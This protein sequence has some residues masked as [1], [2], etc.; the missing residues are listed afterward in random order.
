M[1]YLSDFTNIH[2][3]IDYIWLLFHQ[4]ILFREQNFLPYFVY[5]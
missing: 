1:R 4:C 2:L 5:I 3:S